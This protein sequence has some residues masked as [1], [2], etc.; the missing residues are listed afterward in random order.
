MLVTGDI[1]AAVGRMHA[2]LATL[3]DDLDAADRLLG[4]GDTGM[5]VASVVSAWNAGLGSEPAGDVGTLLQAL[6]R[7]ARGTEPWPGRLGFPLAGWVNARPG[8]CR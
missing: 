7:A 3:R 5:T 6:G 8:R 2:C 4:D 1:V